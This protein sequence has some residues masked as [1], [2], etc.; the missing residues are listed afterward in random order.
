[1]RMIRGREGG[2]MRGFTPCLRIKQYFVYP[3]LR[4]ANLFGSPPLLLKHLKLLKHNPP[5]CW[6]QNLSPKLEPPASEAL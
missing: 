1:M 6:P 4:K 3:W 5:S 2:N